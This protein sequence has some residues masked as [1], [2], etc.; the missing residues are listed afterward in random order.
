MLS[1]KVDPNGKRQIIDN[2]NLK[3]RNNM[4]ANSENLKI[5][6]IC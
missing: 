5:S 1:S 2:E 4:M 3:R 6:L